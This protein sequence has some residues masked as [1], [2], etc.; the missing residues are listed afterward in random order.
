[1]DAAETRRAQAALT[2][3]LQQIEA[4]KIEATTSQRAFIAGAVAGLKAQEEAATQN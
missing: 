2:E 4:E 1:M 3:V